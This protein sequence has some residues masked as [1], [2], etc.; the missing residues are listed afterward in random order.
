ATGAVSGVLGWSNPS[1]FMDELND[2][3]RIVTTWNGNHR[4]TVLREGANR[5]LT[6]LARLPSGAR[7]QTIGKPGES[8]FAVRFVGERAHVVT[9]RTIDPLVVIDLHDPADPAIAGELV[10][11]GFARYLRS[12]DSSVGQLLLSIGQEAQGGRASGVKVELFDVNDIA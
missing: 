6:E 9:S 8:V 7:P 3:L 11:P 2:N 10:V 1:Y 12:V 5:K 4:L